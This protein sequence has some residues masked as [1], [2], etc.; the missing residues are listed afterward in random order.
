MPY[1]VING[2]QKINYRV[3]GSAGRAIV[4][5][6]GFGASLE[7][8]CDISPLL[9]S[10]QAGRFYFVDLPGF[11]GS[12]A[13]IDYK[14][15][16]INQASAVVK[17]TQVLRLDAPVLV[18]HSYGGAV[19]VLA[20]AL[21]SK[22]GNTPRGLILID[23]PLVKAPLPFFVRILAARGS[24]WLLARTV[25]RSIQA[26]VTLHYLFHSARRVDN[27]RIERYARFFYPDGTGRSFIESAR[28]AK[29]AQESP[30][31]D[32]SSLQS[33]P[34][35]VLWGQFDPLYPTK[36][37][38]KVAQLFGRSRVH[39]IPNTGHIPHEESPSETAHEIAD[40]INVT[41]SAH[42]GLR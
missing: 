38:E 22:E 26:R 5:L 29:L 10:A 21:L 32:L 18:G 35:L 24:G 9:A 27:A 33:I 39:I 17:L 40:F 41:A 30:S 11:G 34:T 25:P 19:G 42:G 13:P 31:L 7:T 28:K 12:P 6:H 8:W 23:A 16:L 36:I 1:A 20:S 14:L 2:N 4:F 3:I 15:S 37:A